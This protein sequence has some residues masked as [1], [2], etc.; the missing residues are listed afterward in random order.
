M[1]DIEA[2]VI[3]PLF[4]TLPIRV[5]VIRQ[6]DLKTD[7]TYGALT[8]F[9]DVNVSSESPEDMGGRGTMRK[10]VDSEARYGRYDITFTSPFSNHFHQ[11]SW[12]VISVQDGKAIIKLGGVIS[13]QE[14][15]AVL[16]GGFAREIK[17]EPGD[18]VI[19]P[20]NTPQGIELLDDSL[21]TKVLM[22]PPF[23]RANDSFKFSVANKPATLV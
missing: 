22:S 1:P 9:L 3:L 13:G 14:K 8:K 7:P 20:P 17:I 18:V 15:D 2:G 6:E 12:E 5:A 19:I 10:R 4:E 16:E 21:V 23:D 11:K